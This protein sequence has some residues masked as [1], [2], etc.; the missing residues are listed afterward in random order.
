[1]ACAALILRSRGGAGGT[2]AD[3]TFGQRWAARAATGGDKLLVVRWRAPLARAAAAQPRRRRL[4]LRWRW[5][6]GAACAQA[7]A[8]AHSGGRACS[9]RISW[10]CAPVPGGRRRWCDEL[11]RSAAYGAGDCTSTLALRRRGRERAAVGA[12]EY[13]G[14]W[15]MHC[16]GVACGLR[17]DGA[18]RRMGRHEAQVLGWLA[19][20]CWGCRLGC[21]LAVLRGP[22]AARFSK[23]MPRRRRAASWISDGGNWTCTRAALG[24]MDGEPCGNGVCECMAR[25]GGGGLLPFARPSSEQRMPGVLR[26]GSGGGSWR[27][28][29]RAAALSASW[30]RRRDQ[31]PHA[32]P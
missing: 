6:P 10:D 29:V 5:Q 12:G 7:A 30:G 26:G 23:S 11:R 1:M 21:R 17:G 3:M 16:R 18:V 9:G 13:A 32:S 27:S 31:K 20:R 2:G 28:A 14:R 4:R 19:P 8:T 24:Q 25:G 22:D 15:A